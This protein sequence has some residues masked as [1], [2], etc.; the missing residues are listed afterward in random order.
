MTWAGLI[1]VVMWR[2]IKLGKLRNAQIRVMNE[3]DYWGRV[4]RHSLQRLVFVTVIGCFSD[5]SSDP[6]NFII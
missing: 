5:D 3:H 1:R 6:D 2:T 4:L